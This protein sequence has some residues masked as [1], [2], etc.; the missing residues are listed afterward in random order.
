MKCGY[1]ILMPM[2]SFI[3]EGGDEI[4]SFLEL[5]ETSFILHL[6]EG[7]IL[8]L[9]VAERQFWGRADYGRPQEKRLARKFILC[10]FISP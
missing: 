5:V 1:G 2:T 7:M 8:F 4:E 6:S 10:R 9:G 3:C